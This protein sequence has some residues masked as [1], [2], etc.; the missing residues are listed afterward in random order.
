MR[1]GTVV[2]VLCVGLHPAAAAPVPKGKPRDG[3]IMVATNSQPTHVRLYT[4]DG[5]LLGER[6]FE[7]V[8]EVS[9]APDGKRVAVFVQNKVVKQVSY[10]VHV[11]D[12][13][14]VE[15]EPGEPLASGFYHPRAAW[16]PDG[17]T[18]W[19]SD[20][21]PPPEG[22]G[23]LR[24]AGVTVCDVAGGTATADDKLNG[25][26][27]LAVSPDG[28]RLLTGRVEEKPKPT[29][30][31]ELL[32]RTTFKPIALGDSVPALL[33][34]NLFADDTLVGLRPKPDAPKG[35]TEFVFFDVKAKT[36]SP[37]PLPKELAGESASVVSVSLAPDGKRMLVL[38]SE[39]VDKPADWTLNEACR[40]RR[41][42]VCDRDG[43]NAK[44]ILRPQVKSAA[45]YYDTQFGWVDWR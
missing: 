12:M 25:L 42:T 23:L 1:I 13:T 30:R 20:S 24:P 4:P 10:D 27:V 40:P 14:A 44:T 18:L 43:T 21:T 9:L 33:N 8:G 17:K 29:W 41:V 22:T 35:K 26:V 3:V 16:S 2:L 15:K 28:K 6:S 45:D 36:V 7:N 31:T 5:Q 34:R 38:W 11:V 37:V 32:D 39:E 19:V